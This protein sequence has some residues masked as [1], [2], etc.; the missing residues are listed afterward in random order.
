MSGIGDDSGREREER[1]R[2][3]AYEL[4]VEEGQPEGRAED[5]WERARAL[6]EAEDGAGGAAVEAE[7]TEVE[8]ARASRRRAA[9][10]R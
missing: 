6:V 3:R 4:W 8:V 9:P 2:R 1:I 7:R 5:N 10:K